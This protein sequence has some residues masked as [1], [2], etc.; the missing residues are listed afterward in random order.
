MDLI[1]LPIDEARRIKYAVGREQYG[2]DQFVGN[3]FRELHD[4]LIDSMNYCDEIESRGHALGSIP[5][6]LRAICERVK[7]IYIAAGYGQQ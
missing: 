5:A 1:D 2:G 7:T 3:P 6:Q 4:E